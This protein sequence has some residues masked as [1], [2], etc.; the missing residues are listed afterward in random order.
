MSRYIRRASTEDDIDRIVEIYNSNEEFLINH[1]GTNKID[2][3]FIRENMDLMSFV[4][5]FTDVIID[6]NTGVIV[7]VADYKPD[8]TVYLS[9]FMIDS[10]YQGI[11]TG[12]QIF[13]AFEKELADQGKTAIRLDVVD[14][15]IGN[16]VGFWEKQ[17]FKVSKKTVM[18]W[19]NKKLDALVMTK[20]LNE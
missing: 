1:L 18:S 7:G 8:D 20:S 19:G 14:N 10:A 11:G 4:G 13:K 16:P 12:G 17:G 5:F 3:A 15:Y 6:T 9:L 2:S